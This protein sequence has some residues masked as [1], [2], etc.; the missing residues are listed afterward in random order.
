VQG[1]C[2]PLAQT[3][4]VTDQLSGAPDVSDGLAGMYLNLVDDP[5]NGS[6]RVG[7]FLGEAANFTGDDP[8]GAPVFPGLGGDNRRIQGKQVGFLV[9]SVMTAVMPSIS[10]LFCARHEMA[11]TAFSTDPEISRNPSTVAATVPTPLSACF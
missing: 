7:R 9:I 6:G 5:G 2:H 1:S 3:D 11:E 4:A 10:S 8:K